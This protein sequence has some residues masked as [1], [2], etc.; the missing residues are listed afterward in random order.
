METL[1]TIVSI[2]G[3]LFY[4]SARLEKRIEKLDDRLHTVQTNCIPTLQRSV[5]ALK[6][7]DE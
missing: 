3:G 5:D 2:L 1:I 4:I 7:E 6:K